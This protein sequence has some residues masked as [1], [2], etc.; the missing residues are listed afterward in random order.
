MKR[1]EPT[2][3]T[4]TPEVTASAVRCRW[5]L[6]LLFFGLYLASNSGIFLGNQD[7]IFMW[8]VARQIASEG[9]VAVA[10]ETL[11]LQPGNFD[12]L[13]G[14]DGRHYFPKGMSYSFALA[15]FCW[16]GDGLA[17]ALGVPPD[18]VLRAWYGMFA[19]SLAGPLFAA[20]EV[21]LVLE[22]CLVAGFG[23]RRSALAALGAG[24]GT[25]LWANSKSGFSEPFMGMLITLQ[26][27][28]LVRYAKDASLRWVALAAASFGVVFLSQPA[29]IVL[30]GPPLGGVFLWV[31]WRRHRLGAAGVVRAALAFGLP[32]AAFAAVFAWLNFVR[33]G[34][35]T[36]TGYWSFV[37]RYIPVW[38]GVYGVFFSAGKSV[39]LYSPPLLLAGLGLRAWTRRFGAA[40]LFPLFALA[41]FLGLY[42]CL[43][44]WHGDGA[45]GPRYFTPLTGVLAVLAAGVL[46]PENAAAPR[47]R[48]WW[49][50]LAALGVAVQVIGVATNTAAYFGLLVRNGVITGNSAA[51]DWRPVLYDPELSAI[52]GRARLL[53]SRIGEA[54]FDRPGTWTIQRFDGALITVGLQEYHVLDLWPVRVKLAFG[55]AV[56]PGVTAGWLAL[57]AMAAAGGMAARSGLR[58]EGSEALLEG[59]PGDV[60]HV[61]REEGEQKLDP[62]DDRKRRKHDGAAR[63]HRPPLR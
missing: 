24:L 61:V 15:P 38:E 35:V 32:A 46:A 41:L 60:L 44:T 48:R 26:L 28:C 1:K 2:L 34:D 30:L 14:K 49:I 62:H 54:A 45:W 53:A 51:P 11:V 6:A 55:D 31:A 25:I 57:L 18:P 50:G 19:A 4:G 17:A 37:P 5:G 21:L 58:R 27:Y 56:V 39:F 10:P 40:P 16:L 20:L 63:R 36:S 23:L 33:Y 7:T 13:R 42:G 43:P 9:E 3:E 47:F 59:D 8:G 22:L 52:H 29:M 12:H